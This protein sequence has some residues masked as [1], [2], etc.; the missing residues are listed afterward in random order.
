MAV[1]EEKLMHAV[2]MPGMP[3]MSAEAMNATAVKSPPAPVEPNQS[4]PK[5]VAA[6][7]PGVGEKVDIT[8]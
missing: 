8:A 3:G 6:Q 4:V 2:G 7:A 5:A 1:Q